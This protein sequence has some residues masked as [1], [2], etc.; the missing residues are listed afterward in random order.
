MLVLCRQKE[1]MIYGW[2]SLHHHQT[3]P[4]PLSVTS[5][6]SV[7]VIHGVDLRGHEDRLVAMSPMMTSPQP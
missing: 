7:K 5:F 2:V 6:L 3:F 4:I 1:L